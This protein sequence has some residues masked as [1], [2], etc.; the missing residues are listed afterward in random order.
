MP[1]VLTLPAAAPPLD[2]IREILRAEG[3]ELEAA[4]AKL[5]GLA[6]YDDATDFRAAV[7]LDYYIATV[8]WTS[9]T[10]RA[11][12]AASTSSIRRHFRPLAPCCRPT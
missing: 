11:G 9:A 2:Q 10:G 1:A 5:A 12:L 8:V 4:T 6:G 3:A 7:L